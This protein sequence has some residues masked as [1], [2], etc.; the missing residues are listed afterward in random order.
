MDGHTPTR[1]QLGCA[2]KET[3]DAPTNLRVK[4]AAGR[5]S[6][7]M[8]RTAI[9]ALLAVACALA[10]PALASADVSVNSQGMGFVG[11]GDAQSALAFPSG[12][13]LPNDDAIQSLFAQGPDSIRFGLGWVK[14]YDNYWTCSGGRVDSTR[15]VTGGWLVNSVANTNTAG[16]LTSGWDLTGLG[17]ASGSKASDSVPL[18]SCPPHQYLDESGDMRINQDDHSTFEWTGLKVNGVLLTTTVA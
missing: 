6:Y 10:V 9:A 1:C 3:G 2:A 14:R 17:P 11:K 13:W 15:T 5:E 4:R 8:K 16:K 7:P 12:G 18:L